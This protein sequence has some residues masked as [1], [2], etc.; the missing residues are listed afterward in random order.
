MRFHAIDK[1]SGIGRIG[2]KGAQCFGGINPGI[3][4]GLFNNRAKISD[5]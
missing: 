4:A 5:R 1:Q 2:P 3:S